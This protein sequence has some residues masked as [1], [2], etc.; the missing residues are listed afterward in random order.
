MN[1]LTLAEAA[2]RA[3]LSVRSLEREHAAGKIAFIRLRSKRFVAEAELAR[4]IADG[5]ERVCPS[6][7]SACDGRSGYALAV[8]ESALSAL[9]RAAQR[10]PT[11]SSSKPRSAA[12]RSTLRLVKPRAT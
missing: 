4:Y 7:K 9:Y 5:E 10:S 6:E 11:R 12:R 2:E 3:R 1:L 8:A